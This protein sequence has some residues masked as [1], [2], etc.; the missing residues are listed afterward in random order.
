MLHGQVGRGAFPPSAQV[1]VV[2]VASSKPADYQGTFTRWSLDDIAAK[3]VNQHAEETM[4]RSTVWRVLNEADLKPHRSVYW[5]NGHDPDFDA[6]ARNICQLYVNALSYYQQGRLVICCDEKTGMQIL[7][8]KHP[9]RL[10]QPGKPEKRVIL[11]F[12][13]SHQCALQNQPL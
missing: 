2:T 13:S 10:A 1:E 7:Q 8:R 5:L 4:S 6:K 11:R 9:T 12:K 3:L